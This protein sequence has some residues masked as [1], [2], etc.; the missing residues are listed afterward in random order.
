MNG[1]IEYEDI[2][3]NLLIYFIKRPFSAF[4]HALSKLR[5][6]DSLHYHIISLAISTLFYF[7]IVLVFLNHTLELLINNHE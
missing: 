7:H 6:D 1:K 4:S 3:S 5:I 2:T